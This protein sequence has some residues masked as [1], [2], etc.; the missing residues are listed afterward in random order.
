[1][2]TIKCNPLPI[3][4]TVLIAMKMHPTETSKKIETQ[5]PF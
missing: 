5:P 3:Q 1:M 2:G 4:P